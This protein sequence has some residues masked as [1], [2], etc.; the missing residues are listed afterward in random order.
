[1]ARELLYLV[2]A[3]SEQVP[4]PV[5]SLP[6]RASRANIPRQVDTKEV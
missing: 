4:H 5:E 3:R 2:D 1:M 6:G